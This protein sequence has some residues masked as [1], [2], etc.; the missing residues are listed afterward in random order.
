MLAYP[1]HH[2]LRF[3]AKYKYQVIFPIAVIE[4]PVVTVITGI[5]ISRGQLSPL[6]AFLIIF[7]ADMVSDPALYLLGRFGRHLLHKLTFMKLPLERLGPLERQFE[8]DPWK[9]MIIGKLSY[10]VGSMFVVAAGAARMP[11]FRFLQYMATLDAV[12]SGF[13]LIIGY[14]CGRAILHSRGYLK[15]YAIAVIVLLPL[16]HYLLHRRREKTAAEKF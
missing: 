8:R 1:H 15:Y 13:L 5:L 12:K 7:A 11:W 14:F 3:L 9:T 10:G 16:V 6:P 2:I 4:G